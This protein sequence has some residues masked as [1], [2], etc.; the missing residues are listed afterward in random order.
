[1]RFA[2]GE[3]S[4]TRGMIESGSGQ[5]VTDGSFQPSGGSLKRG[6][7]QHQSAGLGRIDGLAN[8]P[9]ERLEGTPNS[10]LRIAPRPRNGPAPPGLVGDRLMVGQRTLTPSI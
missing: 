8:G 5:C 2:D 9:P 4:V 7:R 3:S 6:P 1:M 10:V